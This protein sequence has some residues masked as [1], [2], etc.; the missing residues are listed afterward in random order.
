MADENKKKS[1]DDFAKEYLAGFE[2]WKEQHAKW[3][4]EHK[5][6]VEK[7]AGVIFDY[8]RNDAVARVI[9]SALVGKG[10]GGNLEDFYTD[11][12]NYNTELLGK[13]RQIE[14]LEWRIEQLSVEL[15]SETE[16]HR[17]FVCEVAEKVDSGFVSELDC[18]I[19]YNKLCGIEN[20]IEQGTLIELPCKVG[21]TVYRITKSYRAAEQVTPYIVKEIII[22]KKGVSYLTI[23]LKGT[24]SITCKVKLETVFLT[25]EEAEKR[26]KELQE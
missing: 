6:T 18:R 7:M 20:K 25:R 19:A 8:V 21:D 3:H 2:K 1:M 4:E 16:A 10:Y 12:L 26:L 15:A 14:H 5:K 11:C 22:D 9:A 23:A 17:K 24:Q 13:A